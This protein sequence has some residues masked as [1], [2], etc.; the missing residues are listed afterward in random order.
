MHGLLHLNHSEAL[1]KQGF[2]GVGNERAKLPH[3]L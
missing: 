1:T 2:A 3:E